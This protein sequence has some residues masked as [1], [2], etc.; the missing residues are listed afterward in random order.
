MAVL[1][2]PGRACALVLALAIAPVCGAESGSTSGAGMQQA[3]ARLGF[4]LVIPSALRLSL[5][6]E[7]AGGRLLSTRL[8]SSSGALTVSSQ[9]AGGAVALPVAQSER[10]RG[11][12]LF[13]GRLQAGVYTVASP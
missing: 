5:D 4:R 2:G 7:A 13:S 11:E 10:H 1:H 6:A 9:R 8:V 3:S 12:G